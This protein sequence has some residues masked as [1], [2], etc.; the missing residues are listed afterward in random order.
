MNLSSKPFGLIF[1]FWWS[2]TYSSAKMPS[3]TVIKSSN[4]LSCSQIVTVQ[5]NEETDWPI[6]ALYNFWSNCNHNLKANRPKLAMYIN[7]TVILPLV[8]ILSTRILLTFKGIMCLYYWNHVLDCS[9]KTCGSRFLPVSITPYSRGQLN[10]TVKAQRV[11][12]S[13]DATYP[14]H[15]KEMGEKKQRVAEISNVHVFTVVPSFI[16]TMAGLTIVRSICE[17]FFFVFL[18]RKLILKKSLFQSLKFGWKWQF[19]YVKP[20]L[21][22]IFCYYSN[23]KS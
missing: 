21:V 17:R 4:M 18:C 20:I 5:H 6:S 3:I 23:G 15:Q 10:E 19:Y 16:K 8:D 13:D 1:N 11:P 14:M 9:I 12:Q 7:K 2:L 22:A